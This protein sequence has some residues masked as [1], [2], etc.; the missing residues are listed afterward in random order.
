[1]AGEFGGTEA[2]LLCEEKGE[3]RRIDLSRSPLIF[4]RDSR[5]CDFPFGYQGISRRHFMLEYRNGNWV[6]IDLDSSNGTLVNNTRISQR[7]LI[8]GE[9]ISIGGSSKLAPVTWTFQV[10]APLR[11]RMLLDA[12]NLDPME[13]NDTQFVFNMAQLEEQANTGMLN[14][15]PSPSPVPRS[16]GAL[17]TRL[18][19]SYVEEDFDENDLTT[20]DPTDTKTSEF[21]INGAISLFS[22]MGQALLDSQGIEQLMERTLEL[23][24]LNIPAERGSVWLRDL[25]TNE[26]ECLAAR[27]RMGNDN[28]ATEISKS[29]AREAVETKK[30]I[31]VRQVLS[32][33]RFNQSA[34]VQSLQICSAMCA[35]LYHKGEV[36]GFLYVDSSTQVDAFANDHLGI[37][38]AM[39]MFTATG[40]EKIHS[41]QETIATRNHL[42]SMLESISHLVLTLDREG[43]LQTVNRCPKR[44]MGI[45]QDQMRNLPYPEWFGDRNAE[46]VSLFQKVYQTSQPGYLG[47]YEI[48]SEDGQRASANCTVVPLLDFQNNHNGVVAILEDLTREKRIAS[49]LGR[50]LSPSLAQ[51]VI[52][53]GETR[54]GGMKQKV[55][56]LFSDIRNYTSLTEAMDAQQVVEMLNAYFTE[57]V[58]PVFAERGFL[59]KYI[60]DSLMAVFGVP[61]TEQDDAIRACR[62]AL[63]M[64]RALDT[65]N[66]RQKSRGLFPVRIGIGLSTGDVIS[67][68]IGSQKRLEYTCIGDGVN[69]ASR[70]EGVTKLY[71]VPILISQF[72]EQELDDKFI[73]REIDC[74][75]VLG[76]REPIRIY[77]LVAA[78]WSEVSPTQ[79][80]CMESYKQGLTLYREGQ[81]QAAAE[82]FHTGMQLNNDGPSRILYLRCQ[83]FTNNPPS[84]KWDGT[85][86]LDNK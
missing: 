77:E 12:D 76:K 31:M 53:D 33:K 72:T 57:M 45:D 14:Q 22:Q 36:W 9:K 13:D 49:A 8:S 69:L 34:S 17:G 7:P 43:R 37:L 19:S 51:R 71:E 32:D 26:V 38:T 23:V 20:E 3:S 60:G 81:W 70:I 68:N 52:Q 54:L 29:I 15:I 41:V 21:G 4:G 83:V 30:A 46:L 59:D 86:D 79:K 18:R 11:S 85:Y 55:T 66:D 28:A 42:Q 48:V 56:I 50:Y 40:I 82:K 84:D 47:D 10:N 25:E 62:T 5:S 67:G 65:F 74:V 24:F 2:W 16:G 39:A 78:D 63:G 80:D 27:V 61:Y 6:L 44:Q 75:R 64:Q 35:P 58:E 1:M 73:T